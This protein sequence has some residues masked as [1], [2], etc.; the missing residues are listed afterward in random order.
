MF[1]NSIMGDRLKSRLNKADGRMCRIDVIYKLPS[2]TLRV[3]KSGWS[4]KT[5]SERASSLEL[6]LILQTGCKKATS[7]CI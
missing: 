4:V 2:R 3:V 1:L 5:R 7:E 6:L